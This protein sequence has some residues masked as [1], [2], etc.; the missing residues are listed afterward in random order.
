MATIQ[1]D[2]PD[3]QFTRVRDA[4]C[5]YGGYS[6]TLENGDPNPQTRGQFAKAQIIRLI[7]DV[8]RAQEV[9]VARAGAAANPEPDLT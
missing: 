8:V 6:P 5:D 9:A 4:L 1:L 3:G 2:I 7:R